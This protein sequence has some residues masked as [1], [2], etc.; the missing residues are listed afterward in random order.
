MLAR[1]AAAG[2]RGRRDA[3]LRQCRQRR[4]ALVA[5]FYSEARHADHSSLG[6]A[7]SGRGCHSPRAT[8]PDGIRRHVAIAHHRSTRARDV[9]SSPRGSERERRRETRKKGERGRMRAH[10]R[11]RSRLQLRDCA[12]RD[13]PR[14]NVTRATPHGPSRRWENTGRRNRVRSL[15]PTTE[16]RL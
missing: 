10:A 3:T 1:A 6:G 13:D 11:S 12:S 2:G 4:A 16:R 8:K 9:H 5:A 15:K 7:T 14:G